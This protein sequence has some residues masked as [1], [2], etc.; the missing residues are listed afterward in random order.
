MDQKEIHILAEKFAD[1]IF[2]SHLDRGI[3]ELEKSFKYFVM[4]RDRRL[5]LEM[6]Y[7]RG[8]DT[9][10][11]QNRNTSDHYR[12][13]F[14]LIGSFLKVHKVSDDDFAQILGWSYRLAKYRSESTQLSQENGF[15]LSSKKGV[16]R[17]ELY[18]EYVKKK[19]ER[20]L[21]NIG[22]GFTG[23][24]TGI[25]PEFIQIAIPDFPED[26]AIGVL[27]AEMLAGKKTSSFREGNSARVEVINVVTN[28]KTGRLVVD[29]KWVPL[30]AKM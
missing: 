19:K 9:P 20:S 7:E 23:R 1:E 5:L 14:L 27:K 18:E 29:L 15:G 26:E 10:F 30:K 25:H 28:R 8:E 3:G 17:S 12:K 13:I 11:S 2:K 22:D 4:V 21:P 24:I 16:S 6:I